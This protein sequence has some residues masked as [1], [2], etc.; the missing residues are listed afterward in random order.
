M[1]IQRRFHNEWD[2]PLVR[3]LGFDRKEN[4]E[5]LHLTVKRSYCIVICVH[6]LSFDS[7]VHIEEY[8]RNGSIRDRRTIMIGCSCSINLDG[9]QMV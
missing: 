5:E 3:N 1:K 8:N 6:L 7:Y 4:Q 9:E 2:Y